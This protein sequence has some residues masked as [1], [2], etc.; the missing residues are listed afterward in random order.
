MTRMPQPGPLALLLALGLFAFPAYAQDGEREP[1]ATSEG[2]RDTDDAVQSQRGGRLRLSSPDGRFTLAPTGTVQVDLGAFTQQRGPIAPWGFLSNLRRARLGVSGRLGRDLDYTFVWNFAA[3]LSQWGS[4][5]T[6]SLSY[7]GF[8]P[9]TLVAGVFKPRATLDEATSSSDLLFLERSAISNVASSFAAGTGRVGAGIEGNGRQWFGAAYATG[10]LAGSPGAPGDSRE[11]GLV[12]RAAGAPYRA[13]GFVLH[14]GA[15]ASFQFNPSL[16]SARNEVIRLNDRPELRLD[17]GSQVDTG[18]LRATGARSAGIELGASWRSL[19]LQGEYHQINVDRAGDNPDGNFEGWY[20][21]VSWVPVGEP[22]RWSPSRAAWRR[23]RPTEDFNPAAGQWG[24]VE[25]GLRYSQ[26]NLNSRDVRG[27]RQDIV[28][29]SLA[30][31]P[32]ERLKAALQVQ[33]ADIRRASSRTDRR[34]QSVALRL[35]L[36]F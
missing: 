17:A 4:I 27:D 10:G 18:N 1:A 22:R 15:S 23:P 26:L 11:R 6:A 25:L 13:G 20:A 28:S 19:Q 33:N 31:Y 16:S 7:D 5:D 36:G 12:F 35:Q 30:W 2:A 8:D 14:A 24:A 32:T 29:A 21:Q 3:P 9:V 34:F